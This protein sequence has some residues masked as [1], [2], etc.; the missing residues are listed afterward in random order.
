MSPE[1][2]WPDKPTEQDP[3]QEKRPGLC[4][5]VRVMRNDSSK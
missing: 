5:A 4:Q 2:H 1:R 3:V